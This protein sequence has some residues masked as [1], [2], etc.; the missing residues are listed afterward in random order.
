LVSCPAVRLGEI[1][2][3]LFAE[4]TADLFFD[5]KFFLLLLGLL[6][7]RATVERAVPHFKAGP[8]LFKGICLFCASPIACP[9]CSENA[10]PLGR[11]AVVWFTA[12]ATWEYYRL[13]DQSWLPDYM[14]GPRRGND[15]SLWQSDPSL[16]DIYKVCC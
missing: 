2:C 16:K 11:G 10:K 15:E 1:L 8:Y 3:T 9:C 7:V 12:V 6:L 13:K 4:A 5:W 14:H